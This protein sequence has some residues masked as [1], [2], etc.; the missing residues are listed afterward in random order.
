M[1]FVDADGEVVKVER[2]GDLIRGPYDGL[3]LVE[4]VPEDYSDEVTI[5]SAK[6]ECDLNVL[7]RR[8]QAGTPLPEFAPMQY[9]DV[10]GVRDI[11]VIRERLALMRDEFMRVPAEIREEFGNDALA[12]FEAV[13]NPSRLGELRERGLIPKSDP[14]VDEVVQDKPLA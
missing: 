14:V 12:F 7:V 13:G 8:L 3:Q 5:Q 4:E 9:G 1:Y 2:S 10:S 11:G 6:D